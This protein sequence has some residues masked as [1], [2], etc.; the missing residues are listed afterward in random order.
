MII[1]ISF[2]GPPSIVTFVA[3]DADNLDSEYSNNDELTITFDIPTNTPPVNSRADIDYLLYFSESLGLDYTGTWLNSQTLR[4]TV[5]NT[6]SSS[7]PVVGVTRVT[8]LQQGNLT[9]SDGTS[10]ASTSQSSFLT[11]LFLCFFVLMFV[12]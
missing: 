3:N 7:P 1:L 5:L 9:R 11:G 2:I 6:T 4:I 8:V 10:I 12:D